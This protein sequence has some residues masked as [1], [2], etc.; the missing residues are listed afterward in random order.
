MPVD[1]RPA[2]PGALPNLTPRRW[3][4][5]VRIAATATAALAATVAVMIV[6]MSAVMLGLT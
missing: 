2:M 4:R 3:D 6:A 1:I 5:L